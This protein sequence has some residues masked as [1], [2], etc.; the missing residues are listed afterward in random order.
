MIRKDVEIPKETEAPDID[1]SEVTPFEERRTR[2]IV[3][4]A[5]APDV[6]VTLTG[7]HVLQRDE[8]V[9]TTRDMSLTAIISLVLVLLVF[10]LADK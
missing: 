5:E 3:D 9:A 10:L 2:Q 1:V 4:E 8:M 7:T 6:K